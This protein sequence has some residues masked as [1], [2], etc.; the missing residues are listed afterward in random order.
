MTTEE[1]NHAITL[2]RGWKFRPD[3]SECCPWWD[4]NNLARPDGPPDHFNDLN[5]MHEAE[6]ALSDVNHDVFRRILLKRAHNSGRVADNLEM[7]QTATNGEAGRG[8]GA[9]TLFGIPVSIFI[10]D[11]TKQ[12]VAEID[13]KHQAHIVGDLLHFR[14][15]TGNASVCKG[16]WL[17]FFAGEISD[18]GYK[19]PNAEHDPSKLHP[20]P[21]PET[22]R[23]DEPLARRCC[24][25]RQLRDGC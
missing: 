21:S 16:G 8:L 25:F 23:S 2:A 11:G 19:M 24:D 14:G 5:A 10:W 7:N 9:A 6:K 3:I 20:R 17:L 18:F 13:Q 12:G 22:I 15:K 4:E 1:K